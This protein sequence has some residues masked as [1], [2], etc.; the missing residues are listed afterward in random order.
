MGTSW[1]RF[2]SIWFG[3]VR[4]FAVFCSRL[5]SLIRSR[6]GSVGFGWIHTD[7]VWFRC[8]AVRRGARCGAVRCGAVRGGAVRCGAV[9]CGAVRCGAVRFGWARLVSIIGSGSVGFD[10]KTTLPLPVRSCCV[11]ECPPA[12]LR[13]QPFFLIS[14]SRVTSRFSCRVRRSMILYVPLFLPCETIL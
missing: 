11:C 5:N 13:T 3:P 6:F 8:G 10:L 14:L 9:R 12:P 7:S 4:L 1:M 2:G